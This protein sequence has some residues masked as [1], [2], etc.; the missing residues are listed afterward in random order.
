MLRAPRFLNG[1]PLGNPCTQRLAALGE[2]LAALFEN[3]ERILGIA[4][5]VAYRGGQVGSGSRQRLSVSRDLSFETLP[6]GAPCALGHRRVSD[7]ERRTFSL[8]VGGNQRLANLV[9]IMSVDR[10]HIPTPGLV[11]HRHVLRID[12]INLRRQLHVVGVIVHDQIRKPQMPRDAAH[13]L[14]NLL[15]DSTVRDIGIGFVGHPL[16]KA[17]HQETFGNGGAQRHGMALSQRARGV[18]HAPQHIH[19]GMA[20]RHAP[21]LAQRLQ[22]L[23]RIGAGQRQHRIEHRRH[24]AGIEEQPVTERIIHPVGIVTQELGVQ[25]RDEIS[26]PHCSAR[27]PRLR[28][29]DHGGRQDAHIVGDT[30]QFRI[31]CRHSIELVFEQVSFHKHPTPLLGEKIPLQR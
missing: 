26:A 19:F 30:T 9:D 6:V 24:V 23:G 21:P 11:L 31:G 20:G 27:M 18:L 13:T 29:F 16:A 17:R 7:D 5:Q 12:L 8:A 4:S 25:Y 10:Q 14:R 1:S 2:D 3:G 28:F 15:L 22:V